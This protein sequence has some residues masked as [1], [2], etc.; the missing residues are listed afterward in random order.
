MSVDTPETPVIARPPQHMTYEE[1][2]NTEFEGGLTEWVDGKVIVHIP[3]KDQH[4]NI[5]E[6][7]IQLL[8]PF[9]RLFKLGKVRVAPFSMRVLPDGPART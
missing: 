4:Q 5:V 3:P 7:L 9:V 2:R 1:Y 8:G 6:F